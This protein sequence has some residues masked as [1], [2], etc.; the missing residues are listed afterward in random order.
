[1]QFTNPILDAL[2]KNLSENY[3]RYLSQEFGGKSL[4]LVKQKYEYMNSFKRLFDG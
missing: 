2:I 1:M 3:Y 4:E